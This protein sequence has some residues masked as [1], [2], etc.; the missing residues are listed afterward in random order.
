MSMTFNQ[1][2]HRV[3]VI[4]DAIRKKHPSQHAR[5]ETTINRL[6]GIV[7]HMIEANFSEDNIGEIL[8]MIKSMSVTLFNQVL[9]KSKY[10]TKCRQ[11]HSKYV[12]RQ[13]LKK[14]RAQK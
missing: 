7:D 2:K 11:I 8:D 1:L 6:A 13:K 10:S 5:D 3:M 4:L 14:A 12:W 9:T